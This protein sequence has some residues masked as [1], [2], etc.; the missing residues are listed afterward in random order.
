MSTL[1]QY[2]DE[3]CEA[4]LMTVAASS[5]TYGLY[6]YDGEAST[7]LLAS[8]PPQAGGPVHTPRTAPTGKGKKH[9]IGLSQVRRVSCC[10]CAFCAVLMIVS[11]VFMTCYIALLLTTQ[12]G[13]YEWRL[14][15]VGNDTPGPYDAIIVLG[16]A[17]G[18][19]F[20]IQPELQ[21]R[22]DTAVD[23]YR[24]GRVAGRF[25]LSGGTPEDGQG[26]TEAQVMEQ[27]LLAAGVP[28]AA[29]L[30]DDDSRTTVEN[31]EYSI[32]AVVEHSFKRVGLITNSFHQFRSF[33]LLH[34][35][36]HIQRGCEATFQT[37]DTAAHET[38]IAPYQ[39]QADLVAEVK[40]LAV[41]YH[42]GYLRL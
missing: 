8:Q 39:T 36:C 31:A 1:I 16:Y 28:A 42:Q 35:E 3:E 34:R 23:V 40:A 41:M 6:G 13:Q 12:L 19:G 9:L 26:E 22:L 11:A 38:D 15:A 7:P 32:A 17:L 18:D 37:L 25:I 5:A 20:K 27:Y 33:W 30:R 2:F 24:A 21:A 4:P 14:L 29:I 10:C